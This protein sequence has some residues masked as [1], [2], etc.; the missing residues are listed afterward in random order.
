[1]CRQIFSAQCQFSRLIQYNVAHLFDNST[2]GYAS[3]LRSAKSSQLRLCNDG[4]TAGLLTFATIEPRMVTANLAP[5]VGFVYISC[6]LAGAANHIQ[7]RDPVFG[8]ILAKHRKHIPTTKEAHARESIRR[9]WTLTAQPT[10]YIPLQ[11]RLDS[12]RSGGE[13]SC[14]EKPERRGAPSPHNNASS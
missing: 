1:M 7:S 12:I 9:I 8:E 14:V 13:R 4:L 5:D 11:S 3:L 10:S 2:F 6:D